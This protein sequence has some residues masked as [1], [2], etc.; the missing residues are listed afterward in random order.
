MEAN[1]ERMAHAMCDVDEAEGGLAWFQI[2]SEGQS[3]YKRRARA[4]LEAIRPDIYWDAE[5]PE[6]G[7]SLD[8]VVDGLEPGDIIELLTGLNLPRQ[9]V[10]IDPGDE[11]LDEA[12]TPRLYP[13]LAAAQAAA[14]RLRNLLK[15][16]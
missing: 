12:V 2:G 9:W 3:A 14:A 1:I 11:R 7:G 15:T 13:T 8:E 4:A 10:W 16:A 6:N 5:D